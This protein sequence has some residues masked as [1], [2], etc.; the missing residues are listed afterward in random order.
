MLGRLIPLFHRYAAKHTRLRQRHGPVHMRLQAGRMIVEIDSDAEAAQVS[1]GKATRQA[2]R[3]DGLLRAELPFVPG[4]VRT[5][6]DHHGAG[7]ANAAFC[8]RDSARPKER[9][10]NCFASLQRF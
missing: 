9:D 4:A 7:A 1:L 3:R 5:G 2:R 6:P 8:H 10:H